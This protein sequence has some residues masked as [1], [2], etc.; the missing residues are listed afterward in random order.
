MK[1]LLTGSSEFVG[2]A[3]IRVL[4]DSGHEIFLFDDVTNAENCMN[5]VSGMDVVIDLS[6]L[7]GTDELFDSIDSAININIQGSVNIMRA[8]VP[9]L[10][11]YIG[12][13]V[14]PDF[15]SIYTATKIATERFAKSFHHNFHIPVTQIRIYNVYGPEQES[16]NIIP[17]FSI[18]SWKGESI[19]IWGDGNQTVDLIHIDDVAYIFLDALDAP[20]RDEII[21]AGTCS[22]Q[23][24]NQVAHFVLQ[25]TGSK[26]NLEYHP[27][28]RGE[29]SSNIVSRGEGWQ[30]LKTRR[31]LNDP[32]RLKQ[33]INDYMD[34]P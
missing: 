27:M 20:G 28:R 4:V 21:D 11:H 17:N 6:S 34:H 33:T 22:S 29:V 19:K 3:V 9:H 1:V 12:T 30:Y 13:T 26:K 10:T 25:V 7:Q 32:Q 24:V 8:C 23:T 2:K 31:P 14:P 16:C 15:P 5:A 18:A